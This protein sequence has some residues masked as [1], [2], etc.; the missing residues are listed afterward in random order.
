MQW[1]NLVRPILLKPAKPA[2][3]SP[4]AGEAIYPPPFATYSARSSTSLSPLPESSAFASPTLSTARSSGGYSADFAGDILHHSASTASLRPGESAAYPFPTPASTSSSIFLPSPASASLHSFSTPP[5]ATSPHLELADAQA[6]HSKHQSDR[7]GTAGSFQST[8]SGPA[9]SPGSAGE[10]NKKWK[11]FKKVSIKH[12]RPAT[13]SQD[14]RASPIPATPEPPVVDPPKPTSA[15]TNFRNRVLSRT[16]RALSLAEPERHVSRRT[17]FLKLEKVPTLDTMIG[18]ASSPTSY[19]H[20]DID[21][22][23]AL[24]SVMAYL[25]DL[26]DLNTESEKVQST[27]SPPLRTSPSLNNIRPGSGASPSPIRR[28]QSSRRLPGPGRT[29]SGGD[30]TVSRYDDDYVTSGRT[31]PVAGGPVAAPS[32][33]KLRADLA[34]RKAVV[35]EI[36]ETEKTYLRGLQELCGIYIT[37][38]SVPVSSSSGKKDAVVPAIERRAVFGNVVRF[39]SS[40][41]SPRVASDGLTLVLD[42]APFAT[43]TRPFSSPTSSLLPTRRSSCQAEKIRGPSASRVSSSSTPRSSSTFRAPLSS[44]VQGC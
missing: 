35:A 14:G 15:A 28:A 34:K 40:F 12:I 31:T 4:E 27:G 23:G 30:P 16:S 29:S 10:S 38:A 20:D 17:S 11:I 44:V 43:S 32:P 24:R 37:A 42:R 26:D 6:R 21:Q 22:K 36:I 33:V 7:P 2:E 8:S 5:P 13:L 9:L 25:R 41:A 1:A 39:S 19:S 18:R 3:L